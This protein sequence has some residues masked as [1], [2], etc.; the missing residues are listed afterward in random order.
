MTGTKIK[1]FILKNKIIDFTSTIIEGKRI[2]LQSRL[3]N[4]TETI[5]HEFSKE[6]TRFMYPK[7]ADKIDET[8]EFINNSINNMKT[9]SELIL[10]ITKK[11]NS[12]FLGC[13]GLHIKETPDTPELGIWLKK[14]AHGNKYGQE[15][16]KT[17]IDW[18]KENIEFDYLIYP[19]D[20]KNIPSRKIP[21]S[22][23][24]T[25]FREEIVKTMNNTY[26]DEVI[27]K[28]SK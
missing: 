5:F 10:A 22:L 24:G 15:A 6:I 17:L 8:L 25:I 16:I 20:K 26:L 14:S 2:V 12:E 13:C 7:P 3:N 4:F 9:N 28:I 21:E 19:V 18:C 1:S 23:G 11:Y 27:Y